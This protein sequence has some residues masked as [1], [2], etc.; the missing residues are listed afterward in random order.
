MGNM[1]V[2]DTVALAFHLCEHLTTN[3]Q[4]IQLK[5]KHKP[6]LRPAASVSQSADL[7][8]RNVATAFFGGS[9]RMLFLR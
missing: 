2:F 6:G 9:G 8:P 1:L 4:P 3:I 5:P 7:R